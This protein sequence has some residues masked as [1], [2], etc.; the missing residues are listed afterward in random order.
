VAEDQEHADTASR[1][2]NRLLLALVLVILALMPS[3]IDAANS[4]NDRPAL[5]QDDAMPERD[6]ADLP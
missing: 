3:A 4:P 2:R 1:R 5:T 6:L